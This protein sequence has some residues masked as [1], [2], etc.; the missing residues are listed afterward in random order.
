MQKR[1]KIAILGSG[2]HALAVWEVCLLAGFEPVGFVDPGQESSKI[3][4]LPVLASLAEFNLTNVSVALGIGH[5]FARERA[6]AELLEEHPDARMPVIIHPTASVSPSAMLEPGAVVLAQASVGP[7]SIVGAGSL[8][9]TGASLDHQ[10]TMGNFASLGPG[11]HTG[12]KVIIGARTMVGLNAGVLQG[13]TV[14]ADTVIGAHSLVRQD[15][16]AGVV[17]YGV[18]CEPVRARSTADSYY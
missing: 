11:A 13:I 1:D 6:H 7:L 2:G 16:P 12:G 5:N 4:G 10:S 18:P 15:I 17:A 9:N 3:Q 14:G 8:L